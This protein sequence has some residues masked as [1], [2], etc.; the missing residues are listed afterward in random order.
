MSSGIPDHLLRPI[1]SAVLYSARPDTTEET[2]AELPWTVK[3]ATNKGFSALAS[4]DLAIGTMLIAES[5]LCVWNQSL[6]VEAARGLFEELSEEKRAGFL[7]LCKTAEGGI[8]DEILNRRAANGF[9]IR[10]PSAESEEEEGTVLAFVFEKV[11]R[12]NH[13][14]TPNVSQSMNV[15]LTLVAHRICKQRL[16]LSSLVAHKTR[17]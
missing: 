1:L 9:A 3:P 12:L 7:S 16:V 2:P 6:T 17:N 15:S 10:L 14:C 4:S 8:D 11:S 13:S 5:P